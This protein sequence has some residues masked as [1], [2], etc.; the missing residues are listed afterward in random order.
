MVDNCPN[1]A[2]NTNARVVIMN[3]GIKQARINIGLTQDEVSNLIGMPI[4]TLRNWEQQVRKPSQW[5]VDLIIDRILREKAEQSIKYNE[6]KGI[7][8]FLTIKKAVSKVA[9]KYDIYKIYLFGSYAKG[10][11]NE[12][13]DIDLYMESDLFG[14]DYFGF[15][16]ELRV[17]IGKKIDL[18]SNKTIIESSPIYEEIKK[19]GVLIYER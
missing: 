1:G 7:L 5:A 12:H 10:E 8:S 9:K 2:Y 13:S 18:L 3:E 17:A 11:A 19:T 15:I 4:K 6:T 14:L 16:E